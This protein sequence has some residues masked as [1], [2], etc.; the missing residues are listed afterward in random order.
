MI[1]LIAN[2]A[3]LLLVSLDSKAL[4]RKITEDKSKN[5]AENNIE[6]IGI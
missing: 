1:T 4:I 5:A 6:K 3:Y 2:R